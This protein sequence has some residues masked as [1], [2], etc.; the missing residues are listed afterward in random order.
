[1]MRKEIMKIDEKE[2]S[3]RG[4]FK[5]VKATLNLSGRSTASYALVSEF[6]SFDLKVLPT[7]SPSK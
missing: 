2:L 3:E 7:S 4:L 5:P 6:F 1:M